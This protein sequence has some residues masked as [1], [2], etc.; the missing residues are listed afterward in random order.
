MPAPQKGLRL[1]WVWN[2]VTRELGGRYVA[3]YAF[4]NGRLDVRCKGD[5]LLHR[6][7]DKDQWMT[8]VAITGNKRLSKILAYIKARYNEMLTPRVKTNSEKNGYAPRGRKPGRGKDLM[9]DPAVIAQ[10]QTRR[11]NE[12]LTACGRTDHRHPARARGRDEDGR[13]LPQAPNLGGGLPQLTRPNM[14]AWMC[15]TSGG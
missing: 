5:S 15:R 9:S 10:S 2:E 13:C 1:A 11:T 12:A 6:V 4:A 14:A 3:P 7:F 8:H